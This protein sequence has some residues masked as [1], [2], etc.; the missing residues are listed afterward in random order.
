LILPADVSTL[1]HFTL[2]PE[3]PVL[4]R[5]AVINADNAIYIALTI[6][7]AGPIALGL[8]VLAC[9]DRR[10]RSPLVTLAAFLTA[11]TSIWLAFSVN[12]F[13][14]STSVPITL[15]SWA[16][17]AGTALEYLIIIA[18]LAIAIRIKNLWIGI[19]AVLQLAMGLG[20]EF[21]HG[22]HVET[23]ASPV[24]VIDTLSTILVLI[25]SVIGALIVLYAI[26]YMSSHEH[27]APATARSTS[28][29]FF[30]LVGF[31]G[32]MNGLVLANDL[33]WFSVFWEATT[34]CSFVL[35]GH[36]GTSEARRNAR[37]AL[38]INMFGGAA[39]MA[40]SLILSSNSGVTGIDGLISSSTAKYA[41]LVFALIALAGL[42][43]SA[44]MPFQ[45]WL[46]GAMVAPTPVSALLHS[47]TM[48][49]AG[50]Y[51]ILRLAPAFAGTKI[52]FMLALSGAFTFA[53]TSALAIGQSNGKKVLAYSTIANLGLIVTCA[54]INTPLAYAGAVMLLCFHSASKGLLFLC[55]GSIEQQIGSRDIED[56]GS[57]LKEMPVTTVMT[58]IGMAS[59]L[60][61]PFGMLLSKWMAIESA[62]E[63]PIILLLLIIGS[64]LTVLFWAK[65]IGRITT[66]SFYEHH[67][68]ER[69]AFTK[70]ATVAVLAGI[71]VVA[72]FAAI[73]VYTHLIEPLASV[74]FR[75]VRGIPGASWLLLNNAGN[76]LTWP[77][78]LFIGLAV[79]A[80]VFTFQRLNPRNVS[81]PFLC[82]ENVKE[83]GDI[84]YE[85]RSCKDKVQTAWMTSIYLRSIFEESKTTMWGN[86]IAT[87]IVISM[88]APAV[89]GVF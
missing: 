26:G 34:I 42:T 22:S 7:I 10:S 49:N 23:S 53:V 31:L 12:P 89:V 35:I 81:T 62:I 40:G 70:M 16:T 51:I 33:R 54:G 19:F 36:D 30:F 21:L 8:G 38:L 43:K 5:I 87:M 28:M 80:L 39:L 37:R 24:F 74:T 73:P 58:L 14:H 27:H 78:F 57:L 44:Q 17:S 50:V 82:G 67:V 3:F 79:I 25:V 55:M 29:F 11:L 65:W 63:S 69:L 48:V 45:S 64:A 41:V 32:A 6:L 86:L 2:R 68:L 61:P 71:V 84:T 13:S 4:E 15:G 46:L 77:L 59:M 47:A 88:F 83:T 66:I 20:G 85:F 18:V 9:P 1:A 60:I 76:V 56:M 52:L 75:D 72:G